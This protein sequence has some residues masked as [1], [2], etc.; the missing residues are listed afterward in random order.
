MATA[1]RRL[2]TPLQDKV[3]E[4]RKTI[5]AR[6]KRDATAAKKVR[7]AAEA[8]S[9]RKRKRK[10]EPVEKPNLYEVWDSSELRLIQRLSKMHLRPRCLEE[11]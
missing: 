5:E 8:A 4:K 7:K 6:Y 1:G 3:G 9:L 10:T 2:A 11:Q